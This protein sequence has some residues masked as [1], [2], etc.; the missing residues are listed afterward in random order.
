MK[1]GKL[2]QGSE[3][4]QTRLPRCPELDGS[5]LRIVPSYTEAGAFTEASVSP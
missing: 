5:T 3:E 4:F 1:A 2:E